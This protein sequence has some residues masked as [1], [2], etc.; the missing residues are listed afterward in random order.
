MADSDLNGAKA[1]DRAL[2]LLRS[3]ADDDGTASLLAHARALSLPPST[4]HRLAEALVAHGLLWKAGR[5]RFVPGMGLVD[6]ASRVE[7][8]KLLARIARAPMRF[9]SRELDT[10]VHLGILDGDMVTYLVKEPRDSPV[11]TREGEQ[12]EAYCSAIGKVI[13]AGMTDD[14]R[15]QYLGTAPFIPL[16][17][18]TITTTEALRTCLE[19]VQRSGYAVDEGEVAPNLHCIAVPIR[20]SCGTIVGGVSQSGPDRHAPPFAIALDALRRT[21]DDIAAALG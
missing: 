21:A 12:L 6:M 3:I 5:G 1:V 15:E 14:A 18:R 20:R 2:R 19:G 9:L 16:T 11:L 17:D 10:T 8:D 4:A 7:P 13:L